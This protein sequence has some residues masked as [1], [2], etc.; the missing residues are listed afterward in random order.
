MAKNLA[1][2][3]LLVTTSCA[4]VAETESVVETTDAGAACQQAP[5][6]PSDY[7][8]SCSLTLCGVPRPDLCMRVRAE[9]LT[10]G[11]CVSYCDSQLVGSDIPGAGGFYETCC[12][13]S[14]GEYSCGRIYL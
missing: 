5:F 6:A 2:L 1:L 14:C 9:V 12:M 8:T 7:Q 10:P 11:A 3:V 13:P 4:G